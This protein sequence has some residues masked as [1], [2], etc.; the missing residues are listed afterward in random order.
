MWAALHPVS[1]RGAHKGA[2]LSQAGGSGISHC[3]H[4]H[5]SH[6][7]LFPREEI[8]PLS[9]EGYEKITLTPSGCEMR[10]KEVYF[11]VGV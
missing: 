3:S 1:G 6:A 8:P 2:V 7:A 10:K 5:P 11:G 9:L 4:T